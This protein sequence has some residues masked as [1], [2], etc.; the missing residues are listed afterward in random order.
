MTLEL[1]FSKSLIMIPLKSLILTPRILAVVI[2]PLIWGILAINWLN[3]L[4]NDQN[5]P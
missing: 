1:K 2:F 3:P 4:K 5:D